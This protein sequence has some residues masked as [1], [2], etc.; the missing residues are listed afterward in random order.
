M[1]KPTLEKIHDRLQ[2][3]AAEDGAVIYNIHYCNAGIGI[4]WHESSREVMVL[5]EEI[6][7]KAIE[8]AG[9]AHYGQKDKQGNPFILHLQVVADNVDGLLEKVVAWLHDVVEDSHYTLRH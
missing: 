4:Q 7:A 2:E 8:V 6:L 9:K 5:P 3:L 1:A